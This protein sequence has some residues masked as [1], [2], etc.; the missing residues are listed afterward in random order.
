M[1]TK[2]IKGGSKLLL[3]IIIILVLLILT[4][5][6]VIGYLLFFGGDYEEVYQNREI[7][8]PTKNL[9]VE[10]SVQKFDE[11]FIYYVLYSIKAYN[12]HEPPLS[13]DKPKIAFYVEN[14][15]Y[16]AIIDE[17]EILVSK[18]DLSGIDIIIRTTKEEAVK[19]I[20]DKDY[21]ETSFRLKRSGL[22]LVAGKTK[23]ASKGYLQLY[24]QLTG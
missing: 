12:L 7:V 1:K 2:Y 21:I 23:L 24:R 4:V 5:I 18:G 9:S 11:T 15:A 3:F 22:E 8:D 6:A 14:E 17:G 16:N 13:S 10:E 20:K 19:M